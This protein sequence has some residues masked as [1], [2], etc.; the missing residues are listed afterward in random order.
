MSDDKLR[1]ALV[2]RIDASLGSPVTTLLA[3]YDHASDYESHGGAVDGSLYG[4]RDESYAEAVGM[5]ITNDAPGQGENGS[6]GGFKVVQS[7]AHQ[8]IYGADSD[9]I[10]IAVIAGL[11]YPSRVG[12]QMLNELH[13]EFKPQFGEEA[14]TASA[15]TMTT[16][17]KS[18]LKKVCK[19]YSNLEQVD[20]ASALTGKI[21]DVK[22]Q[23]QDNIASMLN[24]IEKTEAVSSQADQLSEQASVFKKKSTE[25]KKQMK[26]KN[27][28]MTL[29][30]IAI[31]TGILIVILVP[32][33]MRAK[34]GSS[35]DEN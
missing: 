23:M 11:R 34:K 18:I 22:V 20:K 17:S 14:K 4:G 32:M 31:V 5:V 7:D 10:C 35:N 19:K 27:L 6:I 33:I 2:Y 13:K 30:L 16:K 1:C 26:C 3:K 28:K 12:T 15:N 8:V 21:D 25:L 24:N 29:I 9:G